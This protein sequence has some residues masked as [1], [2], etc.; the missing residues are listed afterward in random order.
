M[1]LAGRDGFQAWAGHS[2]IVPLHRRPPPFYEHRLEIF[3]RVRYGEKFYYRCGPLPTL[4]VVMITKLS[5]IGISSKNSI[6][7]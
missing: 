6:S 2:A 1:E 3:G 5:L 4:L 7:L